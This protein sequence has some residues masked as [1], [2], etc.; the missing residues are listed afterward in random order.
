[1]LRAWYYVILIDSIFNTN[2]YRKPVIQ[3]TG[4]TP[5]QKNF[6]IGLE[7]VENE[8]ADTYVWVLNQL[9]MLLGERQPTVF[10]TDKERGLAVALRTV[11]PETLYLLCV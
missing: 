9:R 11:F 8:K 10:V 3:L 4:V 7:L 2:K 1:M 5:V 6:S